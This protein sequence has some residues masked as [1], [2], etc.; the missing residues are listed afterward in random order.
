ML[1]FYGLKLDLE[2]DNMDDA[3]NKLN[4]SEYVIC[5]LIYRGV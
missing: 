1:L 3:F 4:D 5:F 2:T